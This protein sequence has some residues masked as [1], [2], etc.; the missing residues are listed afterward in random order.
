MIEVFI[1]SSMG[2]EEENQQPTI[3]DT[4][5]NKNWHIDE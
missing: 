5:A 2:S 4:H 3:T 1:H